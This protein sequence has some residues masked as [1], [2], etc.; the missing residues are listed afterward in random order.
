MVKEDYTGLSSLAVPLA[1]SW[2]SNPKILRTVKMM[3]P[4]LTL[5]RNCG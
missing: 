2:Q 4:V 5:V 3:N 1:T